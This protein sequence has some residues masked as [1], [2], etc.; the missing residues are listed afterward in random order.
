[1][2]KK[3]LIAAAS[4]AVLLSACGGGGGGSDSNT[5]TVSAVKVVG[6]SLADSGTFGYKFTVQST[7]GRSYLVYS[8]QVAA[9]YGLP[10]LC[11]AYGFQTANLSFVPVSG[12]GNYAVAGASVNNYD[13]AYEAVLETI[14]T[15][16]IKQLVD[17][18]NAGFADNDLLIV[19]EA[20]ANDAASLTS[21]YVTQK[22]HASNDFSLLLA[23]LL[24]P[25]QLA[26][27]ANDPTMLGTLYMQALADK[28]VAAVKANALDKGAKRIA[29]LNTLDVTMT[30]KFQAMLGSIAD[31]NSN[32]VAADLQ[33]MVNVWIQA[34]NA[35]LAADV[36]PYA[37]NVAVV[38][39]YTNFNGQI[40]NPSLYGLTNITATVC[41]EIVTAGNAPGVTSLSVPATVAACTDANASSM[42]P[43]YGSNGKS[44]WWTNYLFAD[45]FHPTPY[46]HGL[47]ADI[48]TTRLRA[49][50]WM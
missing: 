32:Q 14:P 47:L 41:D 17:L 21:A 3:I 30:P 34:Y 20:S 2:V 25:S 23:T 9:R 46:G 33:V 16:V 10:P 19:G 37:S 18:G 27:Y 31:S 26:T 38:D 7:E 45:Y 35:R 42:S 49:A 6:A 8:E 5:P 15:S 36:A 12:C 48:V 13:L 40:S 29:V 50:G 22:F 43:P 1:M 44:N 4:A 24:S 39:F 28:L 11:A